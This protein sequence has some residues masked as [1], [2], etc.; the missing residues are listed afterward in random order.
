MD[1]DCADPQ[2]EKAPL[3]VAFNWITSNNTSLNLIIAFPEVPKAITPFLF[4]DVDEFEFVILTFNKYTFHAY[5]FSNII[6]SIHI[7]TTEQIQ[8]LSTNVP[9]MEGNSPSL[10]S[11]PVNLQFVMFIS[12]RSSPSS[13]SSAP[14]NA[15]RGCDDN[16]ID[17]KVTFTSPMLPP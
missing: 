11:I 2:T 17:G 12:R 13:S 3:Q 15:I 16:D 9:R 4:T 10:A 5:I 7:N 1:N 6:A 8:T 14:L